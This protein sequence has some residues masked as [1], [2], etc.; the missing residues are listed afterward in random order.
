MKIYDLYQL[1]VALF[2]HDH[3]HDKLPHS[4]SFRNI[5]KLN[6]DINGAYEIRWAQMVNMLSAKLV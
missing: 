4:V 5:F 1:E 6:Y 3:V 2:I